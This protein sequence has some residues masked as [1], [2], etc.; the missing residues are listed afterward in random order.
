MG[1]KNYYDVAKGR[2][3]GIY[4]FYTHE[5]RQTNKFPGALYHEFLDIIKCLEFMRNEATSTEDEY[6][7]FDRQGYF[8]SPRW[9]STLY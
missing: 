7:V 2:Q 5:H 4:L 3:V 6:N 8:F 9:L 1:D